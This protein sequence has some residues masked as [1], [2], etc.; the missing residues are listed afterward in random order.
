MQSSGRIP[1]SKHTTNGYYSPRDQ[2]ILPSDR[3]AGALFS[4]VD[5]GHAAV[6]SSSSALMDLEVEAASA[7][8][9]GLVEATCSS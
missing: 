3:R 4:V 9:A 6:V 2:P 8:A 7:L 5:L 1:V